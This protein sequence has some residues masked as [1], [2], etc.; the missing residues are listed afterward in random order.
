V[1][2]EA[3]SGVRLWDWEQAMDIQGCEPANIFARRRFLAGS[4]FALG[5]FALSAHGA[6]AAAVAETVR[7]P[8]KT[9]TSLH[10]EVEFNAAPARIYEIFLSSKEF[11]TMTKLPADISP[12]AGGAFSMFGG[13]IV[14]RNIE[15]VPSQRI[16]QAWRPKYWEPGV[17]SVVKFELVTIGVGTKVILDHTGF[18]H[19]TFKGLN[20]GW[21]E[22]YWIPLTKYL[23]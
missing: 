3:G 13:I 12:D 19:G 20:S 15:L 8:D 2:L 7:D 17:Y 16:V 6:R 5:G 1:P 22:R 11:A 14:G 4:A 18:P 23:T 9:R 10:Q 21:P